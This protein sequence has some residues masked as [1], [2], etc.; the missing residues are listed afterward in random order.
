[1]FTIGD[2]ARLAGVSVRMLRHYDGLGLLTP[3]EVDPFTGYR[4]YSAAQLPRVNRLVVLKDLGF[5]LDQIGSILDAEV[6]TEELR[7]MLR[8]RHAELSAQIAADA[9]RLRRVEQRLR[10][11]EKE[12]HM[13]EHEFTMT[14]LPAM[15]VATVAAIAESAELIGPAIQGAFAELS[16][17][18]TRA[19]IALNQAAIATYGFDD[20]GTVIV[21]AAFPVDTAVEVD[22]VDVLDLPQ[23]ERAAVTTHV[24]AMDTI[25]ETWQALGE[26]I[27]T[28]GERP[29]DGSLARE[30]Y[31]VM[32]MDDPASWVTDLQWPLR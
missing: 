11:I 28:V 16:T 12:S 30:V 26:W 15:R 20:G 19:G 3:E 14:S 31:R 29:G 1:M 22:G 4:R 27:E 21:R 23:I 7:G 25:A 32:P 10:L 8:L 13:S 24:G 9:E 2:F 6:S 18:L 5:R 17:S